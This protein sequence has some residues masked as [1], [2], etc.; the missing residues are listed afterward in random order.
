MPA[1]HSNV[2]AL[3][4]KEDDPTYALSWIQEKM[5]QGATGF[6]VVS[7]GPDRSM[8]GI[9]SGDCDNRDF[10]FV[11]QIVDEMTVDGGPE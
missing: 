1:D 7:F 11:H 5:A 8:K 9:F 10:Y 3:R 6:F 2:H 4:T